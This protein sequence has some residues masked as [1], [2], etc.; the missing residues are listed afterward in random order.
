MLVKACFNQ[1]MVDIMVELSVDQHPVRFS[2]VGTL[3]NPQ[4]PWQ[5]KEEAWAP[6]S[7]SEAIQKVVL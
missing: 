5:T 7:R 4:Y 3:H 6:S 2:W 1:F